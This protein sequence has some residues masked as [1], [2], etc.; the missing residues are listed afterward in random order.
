MKENRP[1]QQENRGKWRNSEAQRRA[2]SVGVRNKIV[3]KGMRSDTEEGGS[4]GCKARRS[5]PKVLQM[6]WAS[7]HTALPRHFSGETK[8]FG[9]RAGFRPPLLRSPLLRYV[10]IIS[11]SF[12]IFAEASSDPFELRVGISPG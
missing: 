11:R 5:L 6:V 2:A 12:Q 1:K 8:R 7:V 4:K 9:L 10:N 3:C